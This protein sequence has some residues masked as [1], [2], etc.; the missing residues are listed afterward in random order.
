MSQ[1]FTATFVRKKNHQ[2]LLNIAQ[3]GHT[4]QFSVPAINKW[5]TAQLSA[6]VGSYRQIPTTLAII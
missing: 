3:S 1:D 4:E 6:K 5:N 2:D